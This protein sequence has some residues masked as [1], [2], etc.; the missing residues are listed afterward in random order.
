[1]TD[2]LK[3]ID[4]DGNR[5][6]GAGTTQ[7]NDTTFKSYAAMLKEI[8]SWGFWSLGLGA[9]HIILSGSLSAPWGILLIIVGLASF[10]IRSASMFIIYAVTLAWAAISNI[11]GLNIGWVVFAV[12]QIVLAIQVFMKYRKYHK[13][14]L[15]YHDMAPDNATNGTLVDQAARFFPW[16]GS[17]LGCS[18]IIGLGLVIPI[19]FIIGAIRSDNSSSAP[20]YFVTMAELFLN[21]GVLGFA[22]GLASLLSKYRPKVLAILGLVTGVLTILI[23]LT[24]WFLLIAS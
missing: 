6:L 21:L 5:E 14:E 22:I 4:T 7:S 15:A 18:S 16:T 12:F 10:F 24:L 20:S 17:I 9:L 2:Q 11:T 19:V 8:R 23:V 1:M 13:V 3:P